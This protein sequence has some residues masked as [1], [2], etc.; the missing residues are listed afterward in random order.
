MCRRSSFCRYFTVVC[1]ILAVTAAVDA[2]TMTYP[3][4]TLTADDTLADY[5]DTTMPY[6]V[7]S[8]GETRRHMQSDATLEF[9]GGAGYTEDGLPL[10]SANMKVH[11]P[12]NLQEGPHNTSL[13]SGSSWS[14]QGSSA[15]N[16]SSPL[17]EDGAGGNLAV[18]SYAMAQQPGERL[19]PAER[20]SLVLKLMVLSLLLGWMLASYG[21]VAETGGI[22]LT[23]AVLALWTVAFVASVIQKPVHSLLSQSSAGEVG[24]K[25]AAGKH[26]R[27][28]ARKA[29]LRNILSKVLTFLL[30][31]ATIVLFGPALLFLMWV[32]LSLV[33]AAIV[34]IG[35]SVLLYSPVPGDKLRTT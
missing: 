32:F 9:P 26:G 20:V 4:Q 6:R 29:K 7:V 8:S 10:A 12:A 11:Q 35:F 21:S 18:G 24:S 16:P 14:P 28:E 15:E 30:T 25:S 13:A 1:H 31:V 34:S 33:L 3:E 23:R 2:G 5:S 17:Y 27:R 19:R 22:D